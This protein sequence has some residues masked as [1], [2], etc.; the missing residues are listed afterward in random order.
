MASA[1]ET[2]RC[3]ICPPS[4]ITG[5][6]GDWPLD[7]GDDDGGEGDDGDGAPPTRPLFLSL[8]SRSQLELN[9]YVWRENKP[10]TQPAARSA[11]LP[12]LPKKIGS[13]LSMNHIFLPYA[14]K[15]VPYISTNNLGV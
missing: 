11:Q 7:D 9:L 2:F 5:T 13:T 12:N 6:R 1:S 15:L 3:M 4:T 10:L 8:L 14:T